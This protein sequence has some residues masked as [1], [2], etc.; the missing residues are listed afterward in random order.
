MS[1]RRL[2]PALEKNVFDVGGLEKLQDVGCVEFSDAPLPLLL[3]NGA[4]KSATH[5][6]A[7]SD[8]PKGPRFQCFVVENAQAVMP[9]E[10]FVLVFLR[11]PRSARSAGRGPSVANDPRPS[12]TAR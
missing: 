3:G 11:Q 9:Y 5:P 10:G 12:Q 1:L 4:L 6:T 7:S 2:G 8:C